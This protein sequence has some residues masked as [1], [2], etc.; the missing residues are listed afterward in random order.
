MIAMPTPNAGVGK[1]ASNDDLDEMALTEKIGGTVE[2]GVAA[3]DVRDNQAL[4]SSG[5]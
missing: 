2:I 5:P 1:E 4:L 3:L